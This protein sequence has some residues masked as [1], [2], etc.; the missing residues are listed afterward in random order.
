MAKVITGWSFDLPLPYQAEYRG[1]LPVRVCNALQKAVKPV[2]D[3]LVDEEDEDGG[4]PKSGEPSGT[5]GSEGTSP[6]GSPS[7]LP[8]PPAV[9]SGT[10]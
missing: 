4:G 6:A 9:T 5:G 1:Q 3:A 10:P 2:Q 8:A 7:P